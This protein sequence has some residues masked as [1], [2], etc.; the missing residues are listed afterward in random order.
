M[1]TAP[2]LEPLGVRV[3]QDG[4]EEFLDRT[5]LKEK[6]LKDFLLCFGNKTGSKKDPPVGVTRSSIFRALE[7]LYF[8]VFYP[9]HYAVVNE[10]LDEELKHLT[11]GQPGF[12]CLRLSE[13]GEKDHAA[14]FLFKSW[15]IKVLHACPPTRFAEVS[16]LFKKQN[17][18]NTN[19]LNKDKSCS[20]CSW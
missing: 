20:A 1:N 12:Y 14:A 4:V 18:N 19:I 5:S 15:Q 16:H 11:T 2:S 10:V 17:I 9:S 8:L 13:V 3:G 7:S 6:Y